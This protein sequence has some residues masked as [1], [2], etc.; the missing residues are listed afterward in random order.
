MAP[1]ALPGITFSQSLFW[2]KIKY[3]VLPVE[4]VVFLY[5]FTSLF[6]T[7]VYQQ[8]YYQISA[9]NMLNLSSNYSH[10]LNQT[11]IVDMSNNATFS[12]IQQNTNHLNLVTSIVSQVPAVFVLIVLGGFSD[13]FGRKIIMFVIFIGQFIQSINGLMVVYFELNMYLFLI[14][15]ATNGLTGGFGAAHRWLFVCC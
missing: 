9:R 8:Y 6:H 2:D 10:C 7:Q 14:G 3:Y 1:A 5:I 13:K 12:I 11:D 15:G 4:L